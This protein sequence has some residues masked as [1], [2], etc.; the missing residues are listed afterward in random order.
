MV[1]NSERK[2]VN[3]I[4]VSQYQ[5]RI[6]WKKVA[7]D[8]KEIKYAFIRISDGISVDKEF[9]RNWSEARAAGLVTGIYQ[10]FRHYKSI[11]EQVDLIYS[12]MGGNIDYGQ[13]PP[14]L[15][16]EMYPATTPMP[17]A[18]DFLAGVYQWTTRV[19]SMFGRPG[20]IYTNI[21]TWDAYVKSK[22]I[23]DKHMLWVAQYPSPNDGRMPA[24]NANPIIPASWKRGTGDEW[25]WWQY[26]DKGKV[27][28]IT[29]NT[30]DMNLFRGSF[31]RLLSLAEGV[32][33]PS[34]PLLNGESSYLDR[35]R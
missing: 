18:A 3:G 10:F 7:A 27:D 2:Y 24:P 5:G 33:R 32:C 31:H 19:E 16:V 23:A 25:T 21:S 11:E 28:G 13:L 30:V 6:D 14:T 20:I 9:A 15:D 26:T 35:T 12:A 17:P 1:S 29:A 4:D 34:Q 8:P 22:G